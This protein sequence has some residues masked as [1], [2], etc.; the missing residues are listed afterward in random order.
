[1][2]E[3]T[4]MQRRGLLAWTTRDILMAA[5]LGLICGLL[6]VPLVY[7]YAVLLSFGPL[8]LW[9][10]TGAYF[11]PA[12]FIAYCVRRPGA[13]LVGMLLVGLVQLPFTP[14]GAAFLMSALL[15]G[16]VTEPLVALTTRYRYFGAGRMAL[17]GALDGLLFFL[18]FGL[19]LGTASFTIG[20]QAGIAAA[21]TT[22]CLLGVLGAKGLADVV[23]RT[24]VLSGTTL[25]REHTPDV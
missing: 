11:F 24:G 7:A 2:A 16:L 18:I 4:I 3:A 23:A 10:I 8:V 6:I 9:S 12:F 5:V 19:L 22:S 1:M 20:M 21:A 15:R 17:L 13:A 14:A 25:G